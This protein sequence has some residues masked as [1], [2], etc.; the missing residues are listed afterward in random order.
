[1]NGRL[2]PDW[3]VDRDEYAR[4]CRYLGLEPNDAL[5]ARLDRHLAQAPFANPPLHGLQAALARLPLT[6]FRIA[7]L[8]MASRLIFP[9]HPIRHVL[10]AVIALH[11]CTAEGYGALS[12]APTGAAAWF[13]IMGWLARWLGSLVLTLPWLG[14]RALMWRTSAWFAPR[15]ELAGSQVLL[16]GAARGLGRDLMLECLGRGARVIGIVRSEASRHAVLEQLPAEAPVK[17]LVA[18]LSSPGAGTAALEAADVD[19]GRIDVV[20]A[21]AGIKHEG[22]SVLALEALRQTV[23]V[24]FLAAAEIVAWYVAGRAARRPSRIALVSSMGRWHGMGST[25]G[26]NASKAALSIWAESLELELPRHDEGAATITVVEP[27]LFE[28]DMA[29]P[30]P[31]RAF[32]FAPRRTV[33]RRIL[34]G[35]LAGKPVVR[36]PSWFALLTWTLCLAGR[37][38]RARVLSRAKSGANP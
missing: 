19:P 8:D 26:Y 15:G 36:P 27:G 29:R 6:P 21:C 7:R 37:R 3:Q 25:A 34:D 38:T 9:Q 12:R 1:M 10:N 30:H 18:D 5:F 2:F 16:T 35:A 23:Q 24:N 28:S 14:M 17:L 13:A 32:L 4:V 33:A 11:E 20:I 22:R 31:G